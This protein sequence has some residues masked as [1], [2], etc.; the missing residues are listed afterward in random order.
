MPVSRPASLGR[1]RRHGGKYWSRASYNSPCAK[2]TATKYTKQSHFKDKTNLGRG[3]EGNSLPTK[4]GATDN[5]N[6]GWFLQSNDQRSRSEKENPH[7]TDWQDYRPEPL[8]TCLGH[9]SGHHLTPIARSG[10]KNIFAGLPLPELQS[11]ITEM[12][13]AEGDSFRFSKSLEDRVAE[14]R[15]PRC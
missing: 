3:A 6:S 2:A 9:H 5:E 8:F 7:E 4:A 12:R 13:A 1:W 11:R 15:R 10:A 14:I